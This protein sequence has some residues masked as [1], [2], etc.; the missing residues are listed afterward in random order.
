L[1]PRDCLQDSVDTSPLLEEHSQGGDDNALEHAAGRKQASNSNELKLENVE[2]GR[3]LQMREVLTQRLLLKQTLG[4]DFGKLE[5]NKLMLL[6]QISKLRENG[7]RLRFATVV[8]E[9]TWGERHEEHAHTEQNSRGELQSKRYEPRRLLLAASSSADE[10]RPVVDPETDHD[11]KRDTQLLQSDQRTTDFRGRNLGVVHGYN[12]RKRT[13]AHTGDPS[14]CKDRVVASGRSCALD[15][16]TN[17][18]DG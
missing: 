14:T 5:F 17:D 8:D 1:Y 13:D 7:P 18:K 6:R 4:P 12:H 3:L 15:N 2:C 16:H 9:P 11:T 10:V